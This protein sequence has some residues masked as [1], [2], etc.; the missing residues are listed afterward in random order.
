L[1]RRVF[2]ATRGRFLRHWAGSPALLLT[3]TGRVSGR[4]V[5]TMLVAVWQDAGRMVVA[6]SDGGADHH[7][8]WYLNLRHA[9]RVEVLMGGRRRAMTA[10]TATPEERARL[11]PE[12]VASSP[13]YGRY[14]ARTSRVIPLVI[15]Q[16][17]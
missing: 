10:R 17:V 2:T 14:Q 12:V 16:E 15:L 13:A 11:W 4:P 7:P 1:H 8:Q 9:P 5:R 6:A 3:T